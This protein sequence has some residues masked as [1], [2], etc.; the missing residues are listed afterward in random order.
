[1]NLLILFLIDLGTH[2]AGSW[3]ASVSPVKVIGWR[4]GFFRVDE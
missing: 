3:V 2:A 4:R 1:M